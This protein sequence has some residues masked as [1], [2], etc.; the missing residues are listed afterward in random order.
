MPAETVFDLLI[1]AGRVVDPAMN[2]DGPGSVAITGEHIAEAGTCLASALDTFDFPDGILLPGLIDLH[3]HPACEG[4]IFGVEPD[5]ELLP[6]GTTTVLSQGD[7]GAANWPHFRETTIE[8]SRTR[9]RLALNLSTIGEARGACLANIAD[10]DVAACVRAF[11]DDPGGHLWGIAVNVSHVACGSTDPGFVMARALEAAEKTGRPLL[12]G[13]RRP[14]EWPFAEQLALLRP[15]DV[16]TYCFR[17]E[18]H[19]IVEHGRVHPAIRA[20]RERGILF[21]VG[22]GMGSF[23]FATAEAAISDGFAPD[24]ISTDYQARHRGQSPPH[25]LLRTMAKLRAAGLTESDVFAAVTTLPAQ[26]LGMASEIGCL[27]PGACADLT[28]LRWNDDAPPLVDVYGAAR[29]GGAWETL[30]V[31]RAGQ[32][33]SRPAM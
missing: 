30:L 4:S 16:V 32:V 5:V 8:R 33:I 13:M 29:A 2:R 1:R 25:S 17:R 10:I 26:V 27:M 3:A 12:Y 23:D 6:H 14:E 31:V 18:P 19:C 9:V 21:D 24:T 22:H 11:D 7:A 15:G 28:V 20:A